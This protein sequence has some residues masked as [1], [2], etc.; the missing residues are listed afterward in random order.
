MTQGV[1][2]PRRAGSVLVHDG[3]QGGIVFSC[4]ELSRVATRDLRPDLIGMEFSL[5]YM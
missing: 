5:G 3:E 1:L 2:G 4:R